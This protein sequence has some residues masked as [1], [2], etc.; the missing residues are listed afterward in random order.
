MQSKILDNL[1]LDRY[2]EATATPCP[3][4]YFNKNGNWVDHHFADNIIFSHRVN[5]YVHGSFPEKLHVHDFYELMINMNENSVEYIADDNVFALKRG[6]AV[7]T[8]PMRFHMFKLIKPDLYE[9][10][11]IYFKDDNRLFA[12][13]KIMR[14]TKMGNDFC[15][16]FDFFNNDALLSCLKLADKALS[17]RDTPYA[18]ADAYLHLGRAFFTLSSREC[19]SEER[20][21]PF[22]PTFIN[23]IKS[24]IDKNFLHIKSIEDLAQE[25]FYSREHISRSFRRYFNTP[26]YEYILKRKMAMCTE[27][28]KKGESIESAAHHSGFSNMSSFIRIFHKMNGYTPTE[29]R[30]KYAR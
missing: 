6:M 16:V 11:V 22:V 18:Y 20:L 28:L 19:L 12:D 27:L 10:Y 5:E 7:L 17:A 24:Y 9:R 1:R 15:A 2:L 21:D 8:K 13:E 3:S 4:S 14:F 25:F 29:Y 26:I 23:E 30:A